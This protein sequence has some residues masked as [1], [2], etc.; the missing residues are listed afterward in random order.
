MREETRMRVE[1]VLLMGSIA[2]ASP[3][4]P[5]DP[6]PASESTAKSVREAQEKARPPSGQ[7]AS[8][9][10]PDRPNRKPR[11]HRTFAPPTKPL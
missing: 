11:V 3:A 9:E 7:M 6:K 5:A 2:V 4:L 10:Q 1:H 8:E